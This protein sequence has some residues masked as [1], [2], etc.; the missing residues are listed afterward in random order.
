MKNIVTTCFLCFLFLSKIAYS[1]ENIEKL[2]DSRP[3]II[4]VMTD[5]QGMGDFSCMGNQVVKTP[6]IDAFYQ[7]STRFTEYHV[8]PTCA[9]TRAA[10]MSGN[11]EF[12]AGVTHTIL[13]RERMA[14]D[15]YTLPQALQSAGYKT[16]LFGKWHLGNGDE[17]LPQNRGFDEVLMHGAG[18]IGQVSL[19][20]FP[21]NKE[22]LY[23]DNVLLH[24]KTIVKTK[25]FCTDVFFDAGLAWTKKQIDAKKPYFT[26][27]SLNAPHAPLI[28]PESYKKRFLELGYDEGTA[29]RYGMIENIDDNFGRLMR[30]LKEWDVLDN[31][32]VIFTTDNGATH[33]GGTLNGKKVKHFNANLK[34]GKNSPNEG[35][36]HVPLFFY[37]KGVLSEGKDIN[38]LTAHIDLYKTFTELAGAKLPE[39]MQSLKGLS[40]IPL[41]ENIAT[42]WEDRLMFTHCG[43]W[44]TGKVEEA[45]YTKMAIRS[46]QWRFVNNKE[47][48]DV[49]NDPGET[50]NI[51]LENPEVIENFKQPYDEWWSNSIPL[52]VNENR[53]RIKEQ[54]LHAK[55]YKQL[56]EKGILEWK[57]TVD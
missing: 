11:H 48:Y 28:A 29:G 53:K 42:N 9:P 30:K 19:G 56:K 14:L 52:M 22:N 6:N 51:A 49:I 31:T 13:E 20:D 5:D 41:L 46:Q 1:Q 33:L 2:K 54:P 38:Q 50:K 45:K 25:G 4:F 16:G 12:R 43:R 15:V 55:Y 21:A 27:L 37:W 35:G 44:K 57:P 26:Y 17:Y 18:G 8:S 47:L 32:L 3:N 7:K 40:L 23:F 34:G 10:L 39:T 24:N 36:N